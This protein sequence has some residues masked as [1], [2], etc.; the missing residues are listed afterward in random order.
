MNETFSRVPESD[1]EASY[2]Q[3]HQMDCVFALPGTS[4]CLYILWWW[5]DQK[6]LCWMLFLQL[7]NKTPRLLAWLVN[8]LLAKCNSEFYRQINK[9]VFCH[10]RK[11]V[12][13]RLFYRWRVHTHSRL[14][15]LD[16]YS[17]AV[18]C[19]IPPLGNKWCMKRRCTNSA[20][21]THRTLPVIMCSFWWVLAVTPGHNFHSAP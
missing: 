13:E 7:Y 19:E 3:G 15:Q 10:E 14:R 18:L 16:S 17:K 5:K 9:H 8:R 2:W 4:I 12:A 21:S 1:Q 6:I 20:G 11:G